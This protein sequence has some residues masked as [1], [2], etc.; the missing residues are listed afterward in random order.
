MS[1]SNQNSPSLFSDDIQ[2]YYTL[3]GVSNPN[4][5]MLCVIFNM[6]WGLRYKQDKH[7]PDAIEQLKAQGAIFELACK[8]SGR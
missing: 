5:L 3:F 2:Q 1:K 7:D 4:D 8:H 6:L